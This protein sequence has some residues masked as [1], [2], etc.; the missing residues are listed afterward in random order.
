MRALFSLS[1]LSLLV[2]CNGEPHDH[3]QS[4]S[5]DH[6]GDHSAHDDKQD[7]HDDGHDQMSDAPMNPSELMTSSEAFLL[8]LTP[9]LAAPGETS[10]LQVEVLA[11]G[12]PADVTLS[13]VEPWMPAHGHGVDDAPAITAATDE[14]GVFEVSWSFSMGGMWELTF[15]VTDGQGETHTAVAAYKID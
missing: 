8:K 3:D 14:V 11:D 5:D 10:S 9:S 12:E 7:D 6:S 13:G 4:H 1:L 15:T 2:A